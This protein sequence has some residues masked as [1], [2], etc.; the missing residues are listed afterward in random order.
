MIHAETP[1]DEYRRWGMAGGVALAAHVVAI[2]L[3]AAAVRS[4]EPPVPEP[5]VLVDLP[6]PLGVAEASPQAVEQAQP[7]VVSSQVP[8]PPVDVPPVNAPLP[9][10]PVILPP[11]PS[12]PSVQ[13]VAPAPVPVA[14]SPAVAVPRLGSETGTTATP[15]NDPKAQAQ[16]AD[17]FALVS[18]HLN[19]RKRY[20]TE[21]KKAMQ[22]GIVTVRFTVHR[23]GSVSGVSIKRSSGHE[24][25][26]QAT[27]DLLGRVAP[28]PRMPS[29]M[30]RDSVTLSL[31]IDYSL[32]TN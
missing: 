26:D 29:S 1:T 3:V 12:R 25:L 5:V 16:A 31:P 10:D 11:T 13:P 19:R 17:Y 8:T 24:L 27:I 20:P 18:A 15:G 6:P 23:D 2:G 9:K 4:S 30:K 14:V 7:D 32:K 22:Q 21:A 28:L